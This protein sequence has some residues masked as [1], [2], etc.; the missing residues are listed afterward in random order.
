M[1]IELNHWV[2]H[3]LVILVITFACVYKVGFV[4]SILSVPVL[5]L[6]HSRVYLLCN[7]IPMH[8]A[9]LSPK[10]P[11]N[12]L[13]VDLVGRG[14]S[15]RGG[16]GKPLLTVTCPF[17]PSTFQYH[18][19]R[20][21]AEKDPEFSE[22][23]SAEHISFRSCFCSTHV[24]EQARAVSVG[25]REAPLTDPMSTFQTDYSRR[26]C[27]P[28]VS[29]LSLSWVPQL[30]KCTHGWRDPRCHGLEEIVSLLVIYFYRTELLYIGLGVGTA[31]DNQADMQPVSPESDAC[32]FTFLPCKCAWSTLES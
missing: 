22:L 21:K 19:A 4:F 30:Q 8:I 27:S 26:T 11:S 6:S 3:C 16:A 28:W 1:Y 25:N 32:H 2:I 10:N 5:Q 24:R 13:H 29:F 12:T 9:A 15:F 31:R 18:Q 14:A 17:P 20:Q 7:T 23:V